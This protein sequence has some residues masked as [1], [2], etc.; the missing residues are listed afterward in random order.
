M[1]RRGTK[2]GKNDGIKE[3]ERKGKTKKTKKERTG[4]KEKNERQEKRRTNTKK[5]GTTSQK[6]EVCMCVWGGGGG[7]GGGGEERKKKKLF[8]KTRIMII[9]LKETSPAPE[10]I[11][12]WG[13]PPGLLP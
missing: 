2:G 6:G 10:N 4:V 7:G 5:K 13:F 9:Q 11:F 12:V 8:C 3:R 1:A